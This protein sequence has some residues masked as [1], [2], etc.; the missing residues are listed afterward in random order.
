MAG[1]V[2]AVVVAAGRGLRAGGDVPKQ[3]RRIRRRAG[4]PAEPGAAFA[5]TARSAPVQPVIHPRR[6]GALRRRP[7]RAST[8][9]RRCPAARP[10]RPRCAPASRRW[11]A[12]RPDIVLVH[13]AA[14]PFASPALITRAIAAARHERRG[15][16]GARRSPTRSRRSTR[17]A[18]SPARSTARSCARC[19]RR[20]PSALPPLL[21]AH[22]RAARGRP[23]RFHRRC[24]ARRMGRAS[25]VATFAGEAGNMK[26]T[27]A[28]DFCR[29]EAAKLAGLGDVRT[30]FGFDVHQFGD[31]DHVMLGGVRIPH[32]R[33]LTGHSDADVVLHALVDAILG[34]LADGDIGVHFPPSDPQWR[35]ASSDR[36]LAFAV[37]RVRARGGRSRIST[38]PSSARRRASARTATPCARASP[39]SPASRRSA[40]RSRRPPARSWASPAA[41]KASPRM[42]TATV[43]LPWS[44]WR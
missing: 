3:Y 39:R 17:T 19:R 7:S 13:D 9:C 32:D 14:R 25:K 22:R 8:C 31:G 29:A 5:G 28:E 4:D 24:R 21:D 38:S 18:A 43:R 35:G 23:R 11:R 1:T 2:A 10:G 27:T 42:A 30:G 26:L 20:R 12:H 44:D 37:E 34:A 36:F 16:P 40:W 33:G 41:A 6:R 15:G